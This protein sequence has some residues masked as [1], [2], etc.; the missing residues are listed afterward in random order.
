MI[1]PEVVGAQ[2]QSLLSPYPPEKVWYTKETILIRFNF[3]EGGNFR[4]VEQSIDRF[5]THGSALR[6][7]WYTN[8]R[9]ILEPYTDVD[10]QS[11]ITQDSFL[12]CYRNIS[13][14]L[15]DC[16]WM[17]VYDEFIITF[18]F[19]M[20]DGKLPKEEVENSIKAIDQKMAIYLNL[21]NPGTTVH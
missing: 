14:D 16:D 20:I 9:D 6:A 1:N 17:G 13:G 19:T 5:E 15:T 8:R 18:Y 21:E 10:F 11:S 4:E 12:G 7:F 2:S 3:F